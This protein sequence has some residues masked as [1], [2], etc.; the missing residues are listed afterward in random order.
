PTHEMGLYE[1]AVS[2]APLRIPLTQ[3]P[4]FRVGIGATT[5]ANPNAITNQTATP[6][7]VAPSIATS[8]RGRR[9][10]ARDSATF[11]PAVTTPITPPIAPPRTARPSGRKI[12]ATRYF[13]TGGSS[14]V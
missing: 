1:S 10:E 14:A 6:R 8:L 5:Y 2:V 12:S 3:S 13:G 9:I 4:T 11:A 7:A